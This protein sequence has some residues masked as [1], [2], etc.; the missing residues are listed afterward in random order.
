[1]SS[2]EGSFWDQRYGREGAIWGEDPSPTA[3][4]ASRHVGGPARVLDVGFGYGR[5]LVYLGRLGHT[6]AGIDLSEEGYR[7]AL[8]R[9]EGAG[10]LPECLRTGA[11]E[12][13]E[14]GGG[15]FD[16]VISH[17]VAHLL[18]TPEAIARF[19]DRARAL[20]RPGGVLCLG[21]RN[22]H[23]LSP[24][25][26]VPVHDG[27]YEYRDRP[28]HRIRYWDDETFRGAFGAD[29]SIVALKR[30]TEAE[31]A[32]KPVACHLTVMVARKP[33]VGVNGGTGAGA[34]PREDT[35]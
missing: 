17:R 10:V 33:A 30:A 22:L 15:A 26:M 4:L 1:M 14:F 16:A 23:D 35:P 6:V 3:L 19:A 25:N 7:Q 27:V 32:H 11:F 34:A 12:E 24:A 21:A 28:G 13:A 29:F 5:D 20:L 9:L 8:R 2:E 18:L 31:S